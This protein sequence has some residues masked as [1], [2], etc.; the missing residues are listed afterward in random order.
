MSLQFTIAQATERL[1]ALGYNAGSI[2][3][4]QGPMFKAAVEAFQRAK[5]LATDGYGPITERALF[6]TQDTQQAQPVPR[7]DLGVAF[8]ANGLPLDYKYVCKEAGDLVVASEVIGPVAYKKKYIG[9]IWPGGQSGVTVGIGIDLGYATPESIFKDW[10]GRLP[11]AVIKAMQ[12]CAGAK[13]AAAQAIVNS[14]QAN[15]IYVPWEVACEHFINVELPRWLG[16]VRSVFPN[17]ARL[18]PY[19][20]GA[21]VSLAFNRGLSLTGASRVE[22]ANIRQHLIQDQ[23]KLIPN[24]FRSMKRLWVGKGLDGLLTRRDAEARMFEQGLQQKGIV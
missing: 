8:G 22:M 5:G 4:V 19:C 9:A 6:E 11:D 16:N 20:E 12:R 24:E 17:T 7:F 18:G 15:G 3:N 14:G 1:N 13:G 23:P 2:S 21:L 10:A